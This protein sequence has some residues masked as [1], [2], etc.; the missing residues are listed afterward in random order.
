M[1]YTK[2]FFS[3]LS[4]RPSR[5]HA[6][7][8]RKDTSQDVPPGLSASDGPCPG[9]C[10]GLSTT[11]VPPAHRGL[12]LNIR[13]PDTWER[14]Y[15]ACPLRTLKYPTRER[16]GLYTDAASPR[17]FVTSASLRRLF[18]H[19]DFRVAWPREKM[20]RRGRFQTTQFRLFC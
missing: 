17:P 19:G 15:E 13:R 6:A 8:D 12:R 5:S 16:M 1:Q 7:W 10:P 9:R 14:P 4:S 2:K 18:S 20:I 3:R 11:A